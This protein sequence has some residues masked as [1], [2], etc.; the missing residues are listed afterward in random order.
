MRFTAGQVFGAL[1]TLALLVS[2]SPLSGPEAAPYGLQRRAYKPSVE[3]LKQTTLNFVKDV[4]ALDPANSSRQV[5][6]KGGTALALRYPAFRE[7]GFVDIEFSK[8]LK[9]SADFSCLGCRYGV[10]A[11]A[12][13]TTTKKYQGTVESKVWR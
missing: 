9:D 5:V 8:S 10:D 2:S 3:D 1:S 11:R 7:L 12:E 4:K 13:K 6:I